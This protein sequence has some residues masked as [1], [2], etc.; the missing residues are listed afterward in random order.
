MSVGVSAFVVVSETCVREVVGSFTVV[1]GFLGSPVHALSIVDGA[2][3]MAS[4]AKSAGVGHGFDF[5]D[6]ELVRSAHSELVRSNV[7]DDGRLTF[8]GCQLE[9]FARRVDEPPTLRIV[10]S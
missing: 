6:C 3:L 9:S 8:A 2:V 10:E 7:F 4:V 5:G 1:E